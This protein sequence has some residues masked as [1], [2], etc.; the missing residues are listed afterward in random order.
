M[1][2][3]PSLALVRRCAGCGAVK[4][5]SELKLCSKCKIVRYCGLECQRSH[6]REHKEACTQN[7]AV[8]VNNPGLL[9]IAEKLATA[10]KQLI[11]KLQTMPDDYVSTYREQCFA[12]KAGSAVDGKVT[13]FIFK[14]PFVEGTDNARELLLSACANDEPRMRVLVSDLEMTIAAYVL[15]Q[16]QADRLRLM[17]M[18]FLISVINDNYVCNQTVGTM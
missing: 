4:T 12:E 11:G 15:P 14:G 7:E 5:Q 8:V 3:S 13:H 6:W 10:L 1:Q 17:H 9:E 2:A 16:P 18:K